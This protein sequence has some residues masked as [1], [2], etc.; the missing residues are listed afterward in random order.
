MLSIGKIVAAHG[1]GGAV[2]AVVQAERRELFTPPAEVFLEGEKGGAWYRVRDALPAGRFVLLKFEGV[3]DRTRAQEL[4]GNLLLV[5][6]A[7]LP[8]LEEGEYYW[9]D[10]I[11]LKVENVSGEALG[12]VESIIET[13]ANDV[14]VVKNDRGGEILL[15][16]L[17]WVILKVDL[18]AGRM[19]VNPPEGL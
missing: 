19:V 16:A 17:S 6:R 13:G 2:K 18:A 12:T 15:P 4:V 7:D 14:Y 11:G 1:V 10:I 3:T 8:E 5:S 9:A